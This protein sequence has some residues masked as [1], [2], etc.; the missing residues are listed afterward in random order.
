MVQLVQFFD[1]KKRHKAKEAVL[2]A[3]KSC[4]LRDCIIQDKKLVGD[5]LLIYQTYAHKKG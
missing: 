3:L 4:K 2:V 1:M 5:F